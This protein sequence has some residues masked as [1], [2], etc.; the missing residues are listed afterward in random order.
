MTL[1]IEPV[2]AAQTCTECRCGSGEFAK[3]IVAV[4]SGN[5]HVS[6]ALRKRTQNFGNRTRGRYDASRYGPRQQTGC[7]TSQERADQIDALRG[8]DA[9]CDVSGELVVVF[10]HERGD[11][12][13]RR[14]HIFG[15]SCNPRAHVRRI[16]A[17]F[18]RGVGIFLECDGEF[19]QFVRCGRYLRA[20]GNR[21]RER[22]QLLADTCNGFCFLRVRTGSM[23]GVDVPS[24]DETCDRVGGRE[25]GHI[26]VHGRDAVVNMAQFVMC[27]RCQA[28]DHG[29]G[30]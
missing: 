26:V 25:N 22:R 30:T 3:F 17:G 13:R 24:Q 23:A 21:A 9:V 5:C 29:D 19:M 16:A 11:V 20:L 6:F 12:G 2:R 14:C 7:E 10:A 27:A 15:P 18:G 8:C 1:C 28:A 4:C